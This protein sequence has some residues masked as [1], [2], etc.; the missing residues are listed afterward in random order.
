MPRPKKQVL[1]AR[2][3][4]RYCCKY[5]GIQFMGNSSDE[6]LQARDEYKRLEAAG[7]A[8]Q[9][10][11]PTVGEY[12]L[13]WLPLHK[14]GVSDKCYN[15]YA[16]QL[17]ALLPIMGDKRLSDVTVDDAAAVWHHFQGYSASTVHRAKM[18]YVALFETAIENDLCRKNPFKAK[19]AQPPKAPAGTHRALTDE[20]MHLIRTTPH[21]M[22][23]AAMIMMCAGLRR[24]E[25]LA[26]TKE[27]IDL[28]AG[29]I[30]VNKSVR[31][32]GNRPLIVRPKTAAGKRSVP[33]LSIL[34]PFLKNAPE[35]A[36]ATKAGELMTDTAFR[37]AWDSYLL[38]LSR[39]AG[40]EISIRPHD[41]RHTYCA[42][43]LRDAGVD[44]KQAMIWMGHADEKM[45][46]RIYDHVGERRT[47]DS[48][49]QVENMLNGMQNG[50][51][52]QSIYLAPV[53]K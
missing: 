50:M 28:I 19:H 7:E 36:A 1:K 38:H 20:E 23:L 3:D 27:D 41:L 13:K 14:A 18:L 33:I 30:H 15:D 24:G 12:I 45:I 17:E 21:R 4:G 25:V 26:L 9:L 42:R 34:Y 49:N 52:N 37:R 29:L 46:L 11:G 44:M 48:I 35:R 22:Q 8:A 43:F 16:K 2:K 6:A 47:R 5:K 10:R 39:A 53:E 40:H 32:S 51:Q 31:F